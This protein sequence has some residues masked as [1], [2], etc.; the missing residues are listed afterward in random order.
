[1]LVW[2]LAGRQKL[3]AEAQNL[4]RDPDNETFCSAAGIWEVAIKSALGTIRV[5]PGEMLA[6][7]REG[8]IRELAVTASHAAH[9]F[10][11]PVHHRKP[12][13]RQLVAQCAVESMRLLTVDRALSPHGASVILAT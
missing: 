4:V 5:Q 10:L 2:W 12:F 13:D 7:L 1:V 8:S 9:V 3:P 6:A 11:L